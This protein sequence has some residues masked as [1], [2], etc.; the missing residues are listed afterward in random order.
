M[1]LGFAAAAAPGKVI[2]IDLAP[3]QIQ[4]AAAAAREQ[5]VGNVEFQCGSIYE[6]PFSD[7]SFDA[8][9]AHA[10]LE[11]LNQPAKALSEMYR[12]AKPG[13]LIGLRNTDVGGSLVY[14]TPPLVERGWDLVVRDWQANGGDPFIGRRLRQLLTQAGFVGAEASFAHEGGG[15]P[16]VIRRIAEGWATNLERP[17]LAERARSRGWIQTADDLKVIAD[18]WRT[19][20]TS[21]PGAIYAQLWF[22]ATA[23]KPK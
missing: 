21:E 7:E 3:S 11:H 13:A 20:G 8:V 5:N 6:L 14:P 18:A 17:E 19:W 23:V 22:E 15:T 2:G 9:F 12:V 1:T 16:D 10:V 4:V